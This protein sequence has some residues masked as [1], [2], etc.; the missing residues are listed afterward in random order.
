MVDHLRGVD[1]DMNRVDRMRALRVR[2][3]DRVVAGDRS[4]AGVGGVVAGSIGGDRKRRILGHQ[5]EI[6]VAR[7]ESLDDERVG[8]LACG[9]GLVSPRSSMRVTPAI[10]SG[11]LAVG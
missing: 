2:R 6:V 8:A 10:V 4:G 9:D 3:R 7:V 1:L 11:A 5:T